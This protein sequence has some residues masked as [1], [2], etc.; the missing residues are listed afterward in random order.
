[1]PRFHLS[2]SLSISCVRVAAHLPIRSG[3]L[4]FSFGRVVKKNAHNF[5]IDQWRKEDEGSIPEYLIADRMVSLNRYKIPAN[6]EGF[7][8]ADL[9]KT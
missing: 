7:T 3:N 4:R 9:I 6:V 8:V 1:M 2:W 5:L